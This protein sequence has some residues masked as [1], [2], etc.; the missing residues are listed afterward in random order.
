MNAPSLTIADCVRQHLEK[1][2]A[3]LEGDD[4][5]TIYDMV[6]LAV[7]RPMLEVVMERAK[8]NQTVASEMLGINRNTLRKKLQ[9]HHLL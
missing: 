1:F 8:Q 3:D 5:K 6:M 4:A 9:Q 7:E 2:F